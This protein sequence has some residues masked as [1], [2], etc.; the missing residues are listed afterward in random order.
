MVVNHDLILELK[1][2]KEKMEK[3]TVKVKKESMNI[4]VM[5][6]MI[7]IGEEQCRFRKKGSEIIL[8]L[9]RV[10]RDHFVPC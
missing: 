1:R 8:S 9:V 2:R 7:K 10:V 5:R 6:D 4:R 3:K